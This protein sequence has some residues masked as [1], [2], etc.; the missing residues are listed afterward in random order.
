MVNEASTTRRNG[1]IRSRVQA[2]KAVELLALAGHRPLR[3][4]L[5]RGRYRIE[6]LHGGTGLPMTV[7]RASDIRLGKGAYAAIK[8]L[9]EDTHQVPPQ[10]D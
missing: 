5:S 1:V 10:G 9:S 4:V 2:Y 7:T 3:I 8:A 6:A